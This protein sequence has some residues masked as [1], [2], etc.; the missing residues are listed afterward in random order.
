MTMSYDRALIL[1]NQSRYDLAEQQLR[2][3]VQENPEHA[4]SYSLL[5]ICLAHLKRSVEALAA[6]NEGLRLSP[7]L[8]YAHY[9]RACVLAKAGQSKRARKD[10]EEAIR[11]DPIRPGFFFQLSAISSD[12]RRPKDSLAAAERGLQLDPIHTGCASLRALSLQRLG[13][14]EEAAA[15]I[16]QALTLDPNNDFTHT[17]QGWRLLEKNDRKAARQHFLEALRVNPENRWAASGLQR[18]KSAN[19]GL[20]FLILY[21]LCVASGGLTFV[22]THS[23]HAETVLLVC[24]AVPLMFVSIATIAAGL[25]AIR[26]RL[27]RNSTRRFRIQNKPSPNARVSS[28]KTG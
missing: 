18:L 17:A 14:K 9:A 2:R 28:T 7:T 15:V 10:V 27:R 23:D 5:G 6:A 11:L 4:W 12:Q 3:S 16:A 25:L 1:V 13:W 19:A 21:G 24:G 8:A 20:R 22:R 26:D